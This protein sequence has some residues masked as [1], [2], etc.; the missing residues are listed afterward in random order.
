MFQF[1]FEA[2]SKNKLLKAGGLFLYQVFPGNHIVWHRQFIK[3]I[4]ENE[5]DSVKNIITF[6][7][8]QPSFIN[9]HEVNSGNTA[10]HWSCKS[11]GYVS[12]IHL[13]KSS[14]LLIFRTI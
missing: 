8:T 12:E 1:F 9:A 6:F 2:P 5:V 4:K 14:K 3:A 13:S 7:K 11:G 10:L